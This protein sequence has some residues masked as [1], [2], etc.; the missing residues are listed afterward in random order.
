M[1][2]VRLLLTPPPKIVLVAGLAL[3]G[4][5]LQA[6]PFLYSPG[7]LLL[8]FRQTGN[9]DDLV[10]NVGA[11]TNYTSI[12]DNTT[13][14]VPAL[15]SELLTATF[16]SLNG[17]IWSVSGATRSP[18]SGFP[19]QTLWVTAP[20]LLAEVPASAWL[21]KG[22]FVQ[23]NAASQIDA[24][25]VNAAAFSSRTPA[26]PAN[27]TTGVAIPVANEAAFT[28]LIGAAGDFSGVFQGNV[29]NTT[30]DDFDGDPANVSRSDL[31][32][33][34]PGTTAGGSI[35]T[36]GRHLGFFELKPDGTLIFST[37]TAVVPPPVIQ[38]I[39]RVG[40]QTS[41]TFATVAGA[42]YR[43]RAADGLTQP[44]SAWSVGSSLVGS[45]GQGVLQDTSGSPVRF[46]VVEVNP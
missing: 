8:A 33:L 6:A 25:G 19:S 42:T 13:V 5:V 10:V 40:D 24:V 1:K 22:Q 36:A 41:I 39:N 17:L 32:E 29:E 35:N 2:P 26:G 28:Q 46:Y 31:F 27:T 12:P 30:A 43:L 45:G 34:L 9:A 44:L 11:A 21:R 15:S 7:D 16:P 4:S 3:V 18:Q 37:R 38:S 20:R 14:V 23:G